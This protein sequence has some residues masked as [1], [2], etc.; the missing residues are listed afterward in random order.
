M[1]AALNVTDAEIIRML[2]EHKACRSPR[3]V[4]AVQAI[5]RAVQQGKYKLARIQC[6][7]C[8]R[9]MA[10]CKDGTP[11]GHPCIKRTR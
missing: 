7:D 3:E 8:G 2:E 11:W 10:M 9:D 6:P 1:K 5:L 4:A